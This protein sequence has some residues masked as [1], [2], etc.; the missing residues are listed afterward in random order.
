MSNVETEPAE[1]TCASS[2]GGVEVL[3]PRDVPLGGPR[4]MRVRRTLPQKQRSLIGA[5]C[6]CD[7]YGPDDVS[8]DVAPHPHTGLQ[9]VSWLFTG[10][11]EHRDSHGVHAHVRPGELNLM[12]GGRGIAHSEVSTAASAVLHGVQLWLALP[13]AHRD[14][15]RDF[16]H[17]V[18]AAVEVN[19]ASVRVFLG[20]LAG[21]ASPVATFTP[22]LGAE[23]VLPAGTELTLA[24]SESFEHGVLLDTGD[25]TVGGTALAPGE[26]GYAGTGRPELA[27]ATREGARVVLLGGEPFGEEI[28]MWWNFVGRTHEEIAAYRD[29]W[30][31]GTDRFGRVEGYDGGRLPA[32]PLPGGRLR[33]RGNPA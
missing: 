20:S 27:L 26:L 29:E 8:M 2:P 13:D 5:W 4:A 7:H 30:Q 11:I 32:P 24:V 23:V 22:V 17:H 25:V 19:G 12:T 31:A 10:E 16:Q 21:S 15:P 14:A 28:V 9:T 1:V 33:P 18:P 3:P 6:F